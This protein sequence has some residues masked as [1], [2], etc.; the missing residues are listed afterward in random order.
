MRGSAHCAKAPEAAGPVINSHLRS[1]SPY[2]GPSAAGSEAP[3]RQSTVTSWPSRRKPPAVL[4][5]L[6][7]CARRLPDSKSLATMTRIRA[8]SVHRLDGDG[9]KTGPE[10]D[11]ES[12]YEP[13]TQA[14]G[15]RSWPE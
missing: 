1:G 2:E 8:L 3:R 5:T 10:T 11:R 4:T 6:I 13:C 12:R 15:L 14:A 7:A 9:L